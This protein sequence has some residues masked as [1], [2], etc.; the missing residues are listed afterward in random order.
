MPITAM[1]STMHTQT[2]VFVRVRMEVEPNSVPQTSPE[3]FVD[4]PKRFSSR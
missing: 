4:F 3:R 2:S 1:E